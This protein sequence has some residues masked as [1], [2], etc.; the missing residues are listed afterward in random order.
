MKPEFSERVFE[1]AYNA[2]FAVVNSAA[3]LSMPWMPSQPEEKYRPYDVKFRLKRASGK[4]WSLMLQHKVVRR[5]D[6]KSPSN[7]AWVNRCGVPYFA[8]G[9]D[10]EQYNRIVQLR[11]RGRAVYYCAPRFCERQNLEDDYRSRGVCGASVW[12]DPLPAGTIGDFRAHSIIFDPP[13][14]RAFRCC[15]E[16]KNIKV[17]SLNEFKTVRPAQ[18]LTRDGLAGMYEELFAIAD[19][20]ASERPTEGE[21]LEN[22]SIRRD[23]PE[24][25]T[26]DSLESAAVAVAELSAEYFGLSWLFVLDSVPECAQVEK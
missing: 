20:R 4:G 9:L 18:G 8:F 10:N 16:P 21:G 3:L 5:V 14:T 17:V 11:G 23:R 24:R 15:G 19:E 1:F 13:G 7:R 25:A 26:V 12:L 22:Y 2:E 6:N